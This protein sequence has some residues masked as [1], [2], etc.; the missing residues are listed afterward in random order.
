MNPL[1]QIKQY[2]VVYTIPGRTDRSAMPMGNGE[3]CASVFMSEDGVLR[4][5]L[6]RTDA[7][8]ENDV[9]AKLGMVR[10]RTTPNFL[11]RGG[12]RQTLVLEDGR[13]EVESALGRFRLFIPPQSDTLYLAGEFCCEVETE[14]SY[15]TW[16]TA[17]DPQAPSPWLAPTVRRADVVENGEQILFYHANG[18]NGIRELA[19]F[20]GVNDPSVVPDFLTGRIFGGIAQ[21]EGGHSTPQGMAVRASSCCLK[22]ATCSGQYSNAQAFVRQVQQQLASA[23]DAAQARQMAAEH[24][25]R[26][27]ADSYILVSGDEPAPVCSTLDILRR[28]GEPME[29]NAAPSQ[30]TRAYLLT[31][32]M[33]A[34]CKDGA[35]PILYNGALFNLT[36]GGREHLAVETFAGTFTSQPDPEPNEE[37]NPDERSWTIE[38]LWQNLRLPYYTM[39]ATGDFSSLRRLF[40]YFLRFQE[41][42]RQRARSFYGAQGQH[43][44]EMCLSCGLL[45]ADIYGR[46]RTGLAP[47][48]SE[49]SW[50]GSIEI[51]PG[52][53]LL[54]LMLEYCRY[55]DDRAFLL[56]DVM[57]YAHG[58]FDYITTRF[59]KREGGC[60]RIEDINCVETYFHTTNPMPIVAGMHAVLH[61]LLETE[62]PRQEREYFEG[63]L[64]QT[65]AVPLRRTES[66]AMLAP[67]AEYTEKRW[68]IELPELYAVYPFRLFTHAQGTDETAQDTFRTLVQQ[69]GM[70][71]PHVIGRNPG[72]PG[73]S[74]WHYIGP[75]AALLGFAEDCGQILR[76]NSALQNPGNRFPAM[77]GAVHDA[78]PDVDHG[79]NILNLLQLMVLQP[80]GDKLYVL[81]AFPADWSVAF[82]LHAPHNTVVTCRYEHG[83]LVS[84]ETDPPQRKEDVVFCIPKEATTREER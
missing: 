7:L 64:R 16:R 4:F 82:R 73:Y 42:N 37:F 76:H 28:A 54:Y 52:L 18:E 68:N 10:V 47:G 27:W 81:P 17:D 63:M 14:V 84:C 19:L 75:S 45:S 3:L 66:G 59:A 20:Q 30:I 25:N 23:P 80:E 44:V 38:H 39:P 13:I 15:H 29:C 21:L 62:L 12:F 50:G 49:N 78:V 31:R 33:L 61:R 22:I 57:E 6:A 2:S 83:T 43:N 40:R 11:S 69:Y 41:L 58:L 32:Y 5:Y 67:A 55:T 46:D 72:T 1:E 48:R 71:Q 36:P 65:P 26:L 79:A 34:C 24:W 35:F 70:M 9:T 8:L 60:V 53:E 74:G 77:W 51:S 56:G